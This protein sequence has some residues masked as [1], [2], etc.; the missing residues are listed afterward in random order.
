M[1]QLDSPLYYSKNCKNG[2][3]ELFIELRLKNLYIHMSIHN[4]KNSNKPT[5]W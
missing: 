5:F 4:E 2:L 3:E 1:Y